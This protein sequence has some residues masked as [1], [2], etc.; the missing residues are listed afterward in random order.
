MKET[1]GVLF[2]LDGV[3]IDTEST[4]ARFWTAIDERFPTGVRDFAT[5]I[6]GSNLQEILAGHFAPEVQPEVRAMLMNFQAD[7]RYDYFPGA[8]ELV[9]SLRRAGV[10]V[11]VVTSSDQGKMDSLAAQHPEFNALFDAIVTGDM[12]AHAKPHPECFLLGARL[13]G[14]DIGRCVVVEDSLKG[15]EAGRASGAR[16]VGLTTTYAPAMVQPLCHFMAADIGHLTLET[17]LA[18]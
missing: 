3:L 1:P 7:M 2:D 10:P 15:L 12:V 11:C 18:L 16:V 9:E 17:L 8:V 5:S 4:Y 14:R 6:K 13:I